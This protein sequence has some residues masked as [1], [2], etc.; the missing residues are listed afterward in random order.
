M[1]KQAHRPF[2]KR[3]LKRN[4]IAHDVEE[5]KEDLSDVC[6]LLHVRPP[7]LGE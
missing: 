5:R 7:S 4:E 1:K 6:D 3:Y 2:L